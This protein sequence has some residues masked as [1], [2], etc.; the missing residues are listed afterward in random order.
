MEGSES[1]DLEKRQ[2][3]QDSAILETVYM[4]QKN[5]DLELYRSS[6]CLLFALNQN[7]PQDIV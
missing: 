6:A 7:K 1:G 4:G 2:V 5:Y 3:K